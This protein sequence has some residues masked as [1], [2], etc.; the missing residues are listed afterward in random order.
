MNDLQ[1]ETPSTHNEYTPARPA[2]TP[3]DSRSL[4]AYRHG[5]TGQIVL[6][7][8][9]DRLA[10]EKHCDGYRKSLEPHGAV[11]MDLCQAI[12]DDRWRLNRSA[13]LESAIFAAQITQ[14]DSV[15]SGNDEVD[16]TLAM[17]RAWIERGASLQLLT[18]YESRIQRRFEKNM[19]ELR[20]LQQ[21][22]KATLDQAL[23]DADLLAKLAESKGEDPEPVIR[24]VFIRFDFSSTDAARLLL[25]YRNLREARK[26][27]Q[28]PKKK[29]A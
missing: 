26:R 8:E 12:A 16:T 18:L 15:T 13:S 9:A 19:A 7:T 21:R 6:L 10:Y 24:T 29:V 27:F 23:E 4:R 1:L 28:E 17:G 20:A 22:R 11:E 3:R 25:R 2:L 5:L 14:P